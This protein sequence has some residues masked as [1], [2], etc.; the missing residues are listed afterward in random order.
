MCPS[1]YF[2]LAR[3]NWLYIG[4]PIKAHILYLQHKHLFLSLS[5]HACLII[6]FAPR[7]FVPNMTCEQVLSVEVTEN[8]AGSFP[9][10]VRILVVES[11]PT[12][13]RIVSKMLQAF[14]YEG[15]CQ[16]FI[17]YLFISDSARL[18]SY[19][20]FSSTLDH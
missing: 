11:D 9:I 7:R 8:N 1:N 3:D 5:V 10:G 18:L 2:S 15:M 19:Y 16:R 4:T 17:S 20:C 12:C 6:S 13:L 14:G